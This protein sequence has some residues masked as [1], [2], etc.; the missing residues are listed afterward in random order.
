MMKKLIGDI[1]VAIKGYCMGAANVIPGVSGGTI[2][3]LTG[4]FGR[5]VD[6][7]NSVMVPHTWK[8]L[9]KGRWK[10]FWKAID[11]RFLL[12]LAI[13]VL[14]SIFSLAKLMEVCLLYTSPSPR[15]S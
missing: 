8:C 6:S 9:L 14:A 15:D 2:A 5:I 11:G 12:A 4:I 1:M 3:L 13:G 10:E 7:L